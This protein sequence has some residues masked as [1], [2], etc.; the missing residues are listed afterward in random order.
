[1]G[2][3]LD[4]CGR[5]HGFSG[6]GPSTSAAGAGDRDQVGDQGLPPLATSF[7]TRGPPAKQ[8][9]RGRGRGRRGDD[10]A[11]AGAAEP[12]GWDVNPFEDEAGEDEPSLFAPRTS[13]A[14]DP[15]GARRGEG[16]GCGGFDGGEVAGPS[17]DAR[18]PHGA[19][20]GPEYAASEV[21]RFLNR[22]V[23]QALET[24]V[25]VRGA[26]GGGGG[27]PGAAGTVPGSGGAPGA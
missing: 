3:D 2:Q 22:A 17:S 18:V 13:D 10:D 7:L 16:E 4:L 14:G 27:R 24:K 19:H 11:A 1:M 9:G 23:R 20:Y 21:A 8:A 12:P 15:G 25:R 6:R 26:G 5:E